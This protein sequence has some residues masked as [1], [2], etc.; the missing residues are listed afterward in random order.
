MKG[1]KALYTVPFML[2]MAV[3]LSFL[4]NETL[5]TIGEYWAM[6]TVPF[7]FAISGLVIKNWFDEE[8]AYR[9]PVR[10]IN[11]THVFEPEVMCKKCGVNPAVTAD[12]YCEGC[13]RLTME[14]TAL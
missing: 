3:A 4:P 10:T 1:L 9:A 12:N 13:H 6:F 7:A 14:V 11:R 2:G 5:S 8:R